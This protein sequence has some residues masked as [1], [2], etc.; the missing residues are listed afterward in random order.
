MLWGSTDIVALKTNDSYN[1]LLSR[2]RKGNGGGPG[3]NPP[4]S[5][6]SH[7]FSMLEKCPF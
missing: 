3:I 7:A 6:R 2:K 4:E 1:Y 5:F